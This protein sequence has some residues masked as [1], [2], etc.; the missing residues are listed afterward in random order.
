MNAAARC[1]LL[2]A[3]NQEA[4]AFLA[5]ASLLVRT[6][7]ISAPM[8][9]RADCIPVLGSAVVGPF[10]CIPAQ[11]LMRTYSADQS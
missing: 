7:A 3:G 9:R 5:A 4:A 1:P 6:L 11:H 10:L 2:L 8:L